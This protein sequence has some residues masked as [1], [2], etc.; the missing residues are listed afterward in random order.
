MQLNKDQFM[1]QG[2]LIIPGLFDPSKL[3]SMRT[4]CEIMLERQKVIWARDREPGAAPGGAYETEMQPRL[5]FQDHELIDRKTAPV[6]E[7]FWASEE[8][9]DICSQLLCAPEPNV[10]N[11]WMMVNPVSAHPGGTGWHRDI[12]PEDMAPMEALANDFSE[13]GP[14]YVQW[15]VALYDDD[16]L[17]VVPGSHKRINTTTENDELRKDDKSPISEGVPVKAR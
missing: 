10:G 9:L 2:Y 7:N 8:T 15:N 11:M 1:E 14:R 16:V 6:I 3:E 17:W 5:S 12:H 13:N 4:S